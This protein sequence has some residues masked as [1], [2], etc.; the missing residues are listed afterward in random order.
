MSISPSLRML[1]RLY[2]P[3][4]G[5]C[6]LRSPA[7]SDTDA[8]RLIAAI[9]E[10][11]SVAGC[12]DTSVRQPCNI[13]L[14]TTNA[15][16]FTER[17]PDPDNP[18]RTAIA[19]WLGVA[20]DNSTEPIDWNGV[21]A[22]PKLPRTVE[23]ANALGWKPVRSASRHE[24]GLEAGF[25]AP[26]RK[27]VVVRWR[28][29]LAVAIIFVLFAGAAIL[30]AVHNR[31]LPT[32]VDESKDEAKIETPIDP[33]WD[34]TKPLIRDILRRAEGRRTDNLSDSE[35]LD[36]FMDLFK[37]PKIEALLT[38][39]RERESYTKFRG[40]SHPFLDYLDSLPEQIPHTPSVGQSETWARQ[41]VGR[42]VPLAESLREKGYSVDANPL[43]LVRDLRDTCLNYPKYF[44]QWKRRTHGFD[45]LTVWCEEHEGVDPCYDWE[46]PVRNLLR[47]RY[48]G[49]LP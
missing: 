9:G 44:E 45:R 14:G 42:L 30:L 29:V 5:Y 13:R 3:G 25:D 43:Q 40:R 10:K 8:E 22:S 7:L 33:L 6:Y 38:S 34:E 28:R 36:H 1:S 49:D 27:P 24:Y 19:M 39:P 20:G 46:P 47:K 12:S 23:Q 17:L 16:C 2:V 18:Q 31:H 21:F 26:S 35:L 41:V 4:R 37:R 11:E 48:S 32:P 15:I